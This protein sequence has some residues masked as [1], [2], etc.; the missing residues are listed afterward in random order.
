[1]KQHITEEQ[2]YELDKVG[3]NLFIRSIEE[4]TELPECVPLAEDVRPDI[5]QMIEFLNAPLSTTRDIQELEHS[6]K[7]E[8]SGELAD[9]LWLKCKEKL[10]A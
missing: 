5:G 9:G 1:M 6:L 3:K 10:N 2:W 4:L 7:I 8:W